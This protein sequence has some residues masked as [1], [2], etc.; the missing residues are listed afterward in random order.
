[1]GMLFLITHYRRIDKGGLG[2]CPVGRKTVDSVLDIEAVALSRRIQE[3]SAA[4]VSE[5]IVENKSSREEWLTTPDEIDSSS[6]CVMESIMSLLATS[7]VAEIPP[8]T[9]KPLLRLKRRV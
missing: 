4:W 3:P 6:E 2:S 9:F 8:N 5:R 1:M 7:L